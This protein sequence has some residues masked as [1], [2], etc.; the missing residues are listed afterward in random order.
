MIQILEYISQHYTWF[1]GGA[2]LILL[3]IIGYYADK[4]NFGQGKNSD[5]KENNNLEQISDNEDGQQ[6]DISKKTSKDILDVS[7]EGEELLQ[8]ENVQDLQDMQDMQ[9]PLIEDLENDT[10]SENSIITDSNQL[11]GEIPETFAVEPLI[12]TD[13]EEI[14]KEQNNGDSD[15]VMKE[16]VKDNITLS[17]EQ[18]DKFNHEF[19]SVLPKKELIDTDLLSDIDDLNFERTQKLDLNDIPNLDDIELPKIKTFS[20]DE[21]DIWKF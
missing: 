5:F 17:E 1:L 9:I 20:A 16:N 14:T 8:T 6:S 11:E 7:M 15:A 10:P 18:F 4:T 13:S 12:K 3:A 19:D 21:Q 2:I